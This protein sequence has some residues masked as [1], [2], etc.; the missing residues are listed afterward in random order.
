[1]MGVAES[2]SKRPDPLLV[3]DEKVFYEKSGDK[4]YHYQVFK[5]DDNVDEAIDLIKEWIKNDKNSELY[6]EIVI[7]ITGG[8]ELSFDDQ[9]SYRVLDSFKN[10]IQELAKNISPILITGLVIILAK[11]FSA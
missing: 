7:S 8:A 11:L 1:M 6:D 9:D 3:T 4:F 2:N 10:V 5:H